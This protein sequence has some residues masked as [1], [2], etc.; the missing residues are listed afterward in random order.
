[1]TG[2]VELDAHATIRLCENDASHVDVIIRA[3][4]GARRAVFGLDA[5]TF[6]TIDPTTAD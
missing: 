6:S 3:V 5:H 1:M 4:H 2:G